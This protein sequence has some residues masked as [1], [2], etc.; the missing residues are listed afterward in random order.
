MMT[1]I[2]DSSGESGRETT[3][4]KQR[5]EKDAQHA[6]SKRKKNN[7]CTLRKTLDTHFIIRYIFDSIGLHL[8]TFLRLSGLNFST[9]YIRD[10]EDLVCEI[11]RTKLVKFQRR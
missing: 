2:I 1:L 4:E 7:I 5:K 9:N 10:L 3:E 11:G 6:D 8:Q